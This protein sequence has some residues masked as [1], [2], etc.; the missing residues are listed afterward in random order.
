MR[1]CVLALAWDL[2]DEAIHAAH[3]FLCENIHSNEPNQLQCMLA[4]TRNAC[5]AV[6]FFFMNFEDDDSSLL[7]DPTYIS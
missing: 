1:Y 3:S 2:V 6:F 7:A 4:T 5:V